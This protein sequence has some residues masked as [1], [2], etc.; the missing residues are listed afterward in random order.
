M[1]MSV[2]MVRPHPRLDLGPGLSGQA[3]VRIEKGK[4][5]LHLILQRANA[6]HGDMWVQQEVDGA[7]D[8]VGGADT[9]NREDS[10]G[11]SGRPGARRSAESGTDGKMTHAEQKAL[12]SGRCV[13][14]GSNTHADA[15]DDFSFGSRMLP[16]VPPGNDW[17]KIS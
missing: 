1:A 2:W 16:A 11:D 3:S 12:A 4:L 17:A 13:R 10:K 7:E 8:A 9:S 14:G 5:L 6:P 15:R